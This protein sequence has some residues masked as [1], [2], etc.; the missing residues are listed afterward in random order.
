MSCALAM[1][2]A[3]GVLLGFYAG[4][5][6]DDLHLGSI[7][8]PTR[9]EFDGEG[10]PVQTVSTTLD[11]QPASEGELLT[12][13]DQLADTPVLEGYYGGEDWGWHWAP[14][15]LIYHSY[16]AGVHEPR[17]AIVAFS[18]LEGRSLWDAT[19]GGRVGMV[20]Y[21]D[22]DPIA[23]SG[24]QL[25]FY[26]A[27]IARLDVDN[28][29]DLDSCDYV[30]GFPITWGDA[31]WQWKW[32]YAH[33]SSHLGD[34]LAVRV[35]GALANRVNYVRDG[36]VFGTS[37]YVVPDWRVYGEFEYAFHHS[38]GA[39][40]I[41]FQFGTEI[42]P[43]GPTGC[44]TP[45]VAVNCEARQDVDFGGY[46]N[47]QAGWLR[48]NVLDQTV[49]LGFQYYNGKNSQYQFFQ[50]SQQQLGAAIWYDF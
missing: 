16:K 48:R 10:V 5:A 15:G 24:F 42:S 6:A 32:G 22:N 13:D 3:L 35:P 45:F 21:G 33:T 29:Q 44:W 2:L 17:M 25:D 7:P 9:A 1:L 20:R 34:E 18:D 46:V 12:N 19:L 47:T 37:Y 36:F 4:A 49:R 28:K 27:A 11:Q 43:A 26:G 14:T 39:E 38:D 41:N 30:F 23:P 8:A 31:Q 50:Q 40:P